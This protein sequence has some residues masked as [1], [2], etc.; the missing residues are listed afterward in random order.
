MKK[1]A[2]IFLVI[3]SLNAD[4]IDRIDD[5][6][7]DISKLRSSYESCQKELSEVKEKNQ[8]LKTEI[9]SMEEL[10]SRNKEPYQ[11]E[12]EALKKEVAN[13]KALLERKEKEIQNL[14]SKIT[15]IETPDNEFPKLIM[16]EEYKKE[17]N[18]LTYFKATTY[19]LKDN[20]YIY[21]GPNGK[22]TEIW[23]KDTSFT[24]YIKKGNW[25]KI[26]GY[27]IN[28]VWVSAKDKEFWVKE[29]AT[30]KH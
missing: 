3:L 15:N 6:V 13:S 7:S 8:V 9:D 24:S 2:V 20:T 19:R 23:E 4:E 16:K 25:I 26:T 1:L 30:K 5:M 12:I 22:K 14:N 29:S 18:N 17:E 27:F 21:D 28:K 11:K 10:N